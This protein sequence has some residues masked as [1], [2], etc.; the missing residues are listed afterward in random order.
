M[1]NG[2]TSVNRPQLSNGIHVTNGT[3]RRDGAST[4]SHPDTSN[5]VAPHSA[6]ELARRDASNETAELEGNEAGPTPERTLRFHPSLLPPSWPQP[7]SDM[8][9]DYNDGSID[10]PTLM[11]VAL[12]Y[13]RR[14][15]NSVAVGGQLSQARAFNG[16]TAIN[17]SLAVNGPP[18]I[19]GFLAT[20][21]FAAVNGSS[22]IYRN[23]A[24]WPVP[25]TSHQFPVQPSRSQNPIPSNI[26]PIQVSDHGFT[27]TNPYHIAGIPQPVP[28]HGST[29]HEGGHGFP[30]LYHMQGGSSVPFYNG[31]WDWCPRCFHSRTFA[32]WQLTP[33]DTEQDVLTWMRNTRNYCCGPCGERF[34]RR[35]F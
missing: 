8:I 32:E 30:T 7:N 19:N 18:A 35:G 6:S 9:D 10:I 27:F 15:P 1:S 5:G 29:W 33:D 17:G 22:A 11:R 28:G 25:N 12:V 20:N 4:L 16:S 26:A 23:I 24:P 13:D 14:S 21:P 34:G 2:F 3:P 31:G